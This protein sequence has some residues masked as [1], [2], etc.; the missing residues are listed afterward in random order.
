MEFIASA[1]LHI[2]D[3]LPQNR[4]DKDYLDTCLNKFKNIMEITNETDSKLLVLAGDIFDS[5]KVKYLVLNAVLDI[6]Y[7]YPRIKILAIPGQHDCRYHMGSLLDTP[8]GI[9]Q[10]T[11]VFHILNDNLVTINNISFVGTGW[12]EEIDPEIKADVL[13][14]HQMVTYKGELWPGQTNYSTAHAI[15]R[16]Y[17]K[18]N[19]IISGDN[20]LP[21]LVESEG[22]LQINCGSMLRKSKDQIE[23]LPRVWSVDTEYWTT[24]PIFLKIKPAEDV[25]DLDKIELE[26]ITDI[27]KK[28]ADEKIKAFIQTLPETEKERPNFKLILQSVVKQTNPSEEVVKIINSIMEKVS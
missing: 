12:N 4:K 8:M 1:D 11:G 24:S 27:A 5:A 13:V 19:V 22:R 15:L 28:E 14:T 16:K 7:Q 10:T 21:H 6:I 20:H 23:F 26:E 9:L 2:C 17:K 3:N 25:F 18:I